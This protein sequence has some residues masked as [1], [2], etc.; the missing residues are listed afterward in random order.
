MKDPARTLRIAGPLAITSVGLFY[1][2]YNIVYF[3]AASKEEIT[4]S[5]QLVAELLFRNIWARK[6]RER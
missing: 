3:A 2:L 1:V 5:G 4:R 6:R